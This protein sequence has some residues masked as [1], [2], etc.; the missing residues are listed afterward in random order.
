MHILFEAFSDSMDNTGVT[1]GDNVNG[2]SYIL[3]VRATDRV[4]R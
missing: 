4:A 2:S 3:V 1:R